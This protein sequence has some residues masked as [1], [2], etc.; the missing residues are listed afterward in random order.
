LSQ[1]LSAEGSYF[2]AE[3]LS[4]GS[5]GDVSD[6]CRVNLLTSLKIFRIR[7]FAA[8]RFSSGRM[9]N[10]RRRDSSGRPPT[11][12]AAVET[13]FPGGR[14]KNSCANRGNR[15]KVSSPIA[16]NFKSSDSKWLTGGGSFSPIGEPREKS[17]KV[18]D[19]GILGIL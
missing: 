12:H 1:P 2:Q 13:T 14:R 9:A 6:S 16:V 15:A 10:G 8:L 17:G 7:L 19:D 5:G 11:P 3:H 4:I 18:C